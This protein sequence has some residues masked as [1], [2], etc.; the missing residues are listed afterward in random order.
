M[1]VLMTG[2]TGLIGKVV[3]ERLVK[4]GHTVVVLS[5]DA[6]RAKKNLSFAAEAFSWDGQSASIPSE[7]FTGIE[8]IIHLAGEPIGEGRWNEEKK[9]RIHDSRVLGTRKLVEALA[10]HPTCREALKVFVQGSA[11]GIYGNRGG[12]VLVESSPSRQE[13]FLSKVVHEWEVAAGELKMKLAERSSGSAPR[14]PIVRTGVVLSKAGG[15][16]VKMLPVFSAGLG[17]VLGSGEQWMSWIH[18]DDIAELFVFCLENEAVDGVLNGVAPKPV[19]NSEF[20]AELGRALKR[21]AFF[22]VPALALKL[23]LGEMAGTVLASARVLPQRT[24]EF[25]FVFRYPNLNQ[26]LKEILGKE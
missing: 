20:T 26:A 18:I 3:G 15:A 12:E 14:L 7:A 4:K 25:G 23:A 9:R 22:K 5:R 17:G 16:L 11:I 1:R 21:P 8:G 13:D 24:Q 19:Q 2:A 6:G 10:K